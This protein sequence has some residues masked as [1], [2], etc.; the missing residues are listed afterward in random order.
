MTDLKGHKAF[1]WER[2]GWVHL[3]LVNDEHPFTRMILRTGSDEARDIAAA[4]IGAADGIE[5]TKEAS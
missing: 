3:E 4:L 1:V 5:A 2:A